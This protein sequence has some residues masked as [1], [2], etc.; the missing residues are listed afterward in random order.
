MQRFCCI[1]RSKGAIFS[2]N[3]LETPKIP[4]IDIADFPNQ[5]YITSKIQALERYSAGV[6]VYT[7]QNANGEQTTPSEIAIAYYA[8]SEKYFE[9][10]NTSSDEYPKEPESSSVQ[11]KGLEKYSIEHES[12][13]SEA[14]KEGQP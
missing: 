13:N 6:K 12:N 9:Q 11:A 1:G 7:L 14:E 8:E 5:E 2:H 10:N 3:Y 4:I